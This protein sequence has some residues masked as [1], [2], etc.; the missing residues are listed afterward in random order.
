LVAAKV[1]CDDVHVYFYVRT[2]QPRLPQND[3]R[4]TL[5]LIDA[6]GDSATGWLGYDVIVNRV[7]LGDG[8]VTLERN[9]QGRYQWDSPE[10]V[11]CRA[12][13]NELELAIPY[14]FLDPESLPGT[15]DFKWGDNIR[16]TGEWS[17]FTLNGDVAPNDRFNYRAHLPT[18]TQSAFLDDVQV[19]QSR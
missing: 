12:A 19:H 15:I 16:Q 8:S 4:G 7:A 18:G 9:V 17:D 2:L 14:S 5:L 10:R 13:G 3:P 11:A 1:S 6:D